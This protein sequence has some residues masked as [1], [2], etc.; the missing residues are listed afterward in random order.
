MAIG[1][2]LVGDP[3]YGVGL[4]N[5]SGIVSGVI[6]PFGYTAARDTEGVIL[7]DSGG[8]GLAREGDRVLMEGWIDFDTFVAHPCD[9][10]RFHVVLASPGA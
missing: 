5:E 7:F 6:W 2:V 9:P 10:P 3:I 1:G 4:R 8:T